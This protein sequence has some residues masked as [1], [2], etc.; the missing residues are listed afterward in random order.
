MT[1]GSLV[2]LRDGRMLG[3]IE[4]GRPGGDPLLYFHGFPGS[5]V[6]ARLLAGTAE[7]CGVRLI[8]VDRP[9]M[10]RST[11]QAGRRLLDW[12]ADVADLA[13]A[14]GIG[15]FSVIGCSGGGPYALACASALPKRLDACGVLAG[16][17]AAGLLLRLA[18]GWLPWLLTPLAGPLFH[19]ERR[20]ALM[21]GTLVRSWPEPDRKALDRPGVRATLAASVAGALAQGS[22]GV[23]AEATLLCGNWGFEL[24][25]IDGARVQLWH[26]ELD[27]QAPI[28]A[29]RAIAARVP[30]CEARYYP[31]E[32]HLS[33][34]VNRGE[35]IIRALM[36]TEGRR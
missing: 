24:E 27:R 1:G 26:G 33:L 6:E 15:R 29:A 32:A 23:A 34:T 4:Y 14:L 36:L 35:E 30:G 13:D 17:G 9:G 2:R 3:L 10:G 12:P 20:A 5:R 8:G 31:D 25:G 11:M 7:R 19:N 28:A 21:L 18:S 16:A 22:Q